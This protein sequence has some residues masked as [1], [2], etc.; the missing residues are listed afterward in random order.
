[1]L[2]TTTMVFGVSFNQVNYYSFFVRPGVRTTYCHTQLVVDVYPGTG[3]DKGT[4]RVVRPTTTL[5]FSTRTFVYT[6]QGV[7]F[8]FPRV[9]HTLYSFGHGVDFTRVGR[10]FPRGPLIQRPRVTIPVTIIGVVEDTRVGNKGTTFT[11]RFV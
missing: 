6:V 4:T 5:D 8:H 3:K 1:M 9:G 11:P 7:N 2:V 10:Y